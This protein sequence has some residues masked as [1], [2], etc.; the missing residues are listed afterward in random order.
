MGRSSID[1][2]F[3][4]RRPWNEGRVLGAPTIARS[5]I[6]RLRDRQQLR[7]CDVV[8]VRIGDIV[9]GGRIRERAMVVQLHGN[10]SCRPV[11]HNTPTVATEALSG[12]RRIVSGRQGPCAVIGSPQI[13]RRTIACRLSARRTRD[14]R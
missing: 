1:P 4:E 5:S 8:K 14:G 3:Q 11:A 2:A 10:G 12:H 6:V 7:G 13:S 9:A